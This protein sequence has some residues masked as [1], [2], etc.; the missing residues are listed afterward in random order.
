M[1]GGIGRNFDLRGIA[2]LH[3]MAD[4]AGWQIDMVDLM[5]PSIIDEELARLGV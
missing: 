5:D 2:L 4:K 1:F 3:R